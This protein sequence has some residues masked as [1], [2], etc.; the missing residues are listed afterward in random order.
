M[1]FCSVLLMICEDDCLDLKNSY[2]LQMECFELPHQFVIVVL[3]LWQCLVVLYNAWQSSFKSLMETSGHALKC[4]FCLCCQVGTLSV[5]SLYIS[6]NWS[7]S[8]TWPARLKDKA[9]GWV[10]LAQA[11][12]TCHCCLEMWFPWQPPQKAECLEVPRLA[13]CG[14]NFDQWEIKA[15]R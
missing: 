9:K 8:P 1:V 12:E 6:A 11:S 3:Q 13:P 10:L 4:A 5:H 14:V 2:W 15:N 7:P